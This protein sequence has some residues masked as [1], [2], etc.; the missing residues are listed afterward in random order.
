[1]VCGLVGATAAIDTL[2]ADQTRKVR[3]GFIGNHDGSYIHRDYRHRQYFIR[4]GGL[5]NANSTRAL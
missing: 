3:G 2:E 4:Y 5:G 1:M